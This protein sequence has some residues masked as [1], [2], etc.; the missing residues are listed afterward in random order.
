[1]RIWQKLALVLSTLLV[2]VIITMIFAVQYSFDRGFLQ[3]VSRSEATMSRLLADTI[4]DAYALQGSW[5]FLR[6]DRRALMQLFNDW[7]WRAGQRERA[8]RQQEVLREVQTAFRRGV[9]PELLQIAGRVLV[10]DADEREV[11]GQ[12]TVLN[13]QASEYPLTVNGDHVGTLLVGRPETLT[14]EI[15]LAFKEEQRN[16]LYLTGAILLALTLLVSW[17]AARM[18]AA[19]VRSIV[20]QGKRLASGDYQVRSDVRRDDELGALARHLDSLGRTLAENEQARRRWIADISHEL[21]TPLTVLRGEVEALRDGVRVADAGAMDSL[22][23]EAEHLGKLVGDLY[24]LSLSDI[25]ALD[26][27]KELIEPADVLL[28]IAERM[29][30]RFNAAGLELETDIRNVDACGEFDADR[31][32][33]LFTNLLENSLRYTDSPGTVR[34][35]AAMDD[36]SHYCI[37]IDDSS[38]GVASHAVEHLF[39]RLYRVEVSRSREHGGAGLGLAIVRNIVIAHDGT[40]TAENS[41]LGGLRVRIRLPLSGGDKE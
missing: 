30:T 8:L 37:F 19:P 17:L 21:R 3:Y 26:Y 12:S 9:P 15:D 20:L 4:E 28:E 2:V 35:T 14:R 16:S 5:A 39:E 10:L 36:E 33:Q 18:I 22:A 41:P 34:I 11:A 27:R 23:A 13:G 24:E 31:L 40:I 7:N 25:G 32:T 29:T 6:A 1:M 38:P